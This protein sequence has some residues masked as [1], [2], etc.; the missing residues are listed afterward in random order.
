MTTVQ[1]LLITPIAH[2]KMRQIM[3]HYNYLHLMQLVCVASLISCGDPRVG[4]YNWGYFTINVY[5]CCG[6]R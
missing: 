1:I 5:G 6:C 3:S 4:P 2:W